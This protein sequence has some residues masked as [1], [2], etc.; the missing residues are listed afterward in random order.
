MTA[1]GQDTALVESEFG[2]LANSVANLHAQGDS[3]W[4]G[5]FLNLTADG[6]ASWEVVSTDSI[7]QGANRVFSLDVEGDVIWVGLGR[8]DRSTGESVQTAGGFLVSTDGG[9]SF[10]YRFPQLDAAEDDT[11]QYGVNTLSALAVIVPQQSPPFDIDYDPATG[12]VWVAGWASGIRRSSDSG[13]T[14]QR[15]V[16]PP[17]D[18]DY[19]HP[20]SVYSF[21][22]E[23]QRGGTGELNHMGFG[24]LVD[25]TGTVWAGTPA[26]LNRSNDGESWQRFSHDGTSSSLPGNWV[27]SIE[28]QPLP[29][30]NPV[31]AAT[32]NSGGGG[33]AQFGVAVTR[34]GGETFQPTLQGEKVYDF[35][36]RGETVYVASDGGLFISDDGGLIWRN[37]RDFRDRLRPERFVRPGA[38]VFSVAVTRGAVWVGTE[39]GLLKSTDEGETWTVS[40]VEVP[41]RPANPTEAVPTVD[42]FAYP[43]PFSPSI[44]RF[45]RFRYE[46]S[47]PGTVRIRVLDFGMGLV[48]EWTDDRSSG[49]SE[50]VWDGRDAGGIRL[51]NG[52]YFY[53]ISGPS[54]FHATGKIL[55]VE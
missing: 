18:F 25:E 39:D 34:D 35:A 46:L 23:P 20:D 53:V 12:D 11:Q 13:L 29:G 3:L 5:P 42:A 30:R 10:E 26:G 19:I 51:A 6:G 1:L 43:N 22:V 14:W 54:G 28:E 31:W 32:W 16:L 4:L 47:T 41:T 40:R 37:V 9:R 36:F 44:D 24:V 8:S 7:G 48:R 2:I 15:V 17:D 55:V 38:S 49:L 52:A 33:T 50:S 45:V 27:I 21:R